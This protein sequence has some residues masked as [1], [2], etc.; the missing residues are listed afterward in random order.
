MEATQ[1]LEGGTKNIGAL[2]KVARVG[3]VIDSSGSMMGREQE[4]ISGF[5]EQLDEIL[6][7]PDNVSTYITVVDFN[8]E[9]HVVC[10]N[11]PA[12]TVERMKEGDYN[13][14]GWTALFDAIGKTVNIMEKHGEDGDSYLLVLLTDGYENHSVEFKRDTLKRLVT[15]RQDRGDWTIT[16]LVAGLDIERLLADVGV[17]GGNMGMFTASAAGVTNAFKGMSDGSRTYFDNVSLSQGPYST[18]SFYSISETDGE[19]S[20]ND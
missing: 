17:A 9:V 12:E 3:I 7:A 14:E 5:N 11:I 8:T 18:D 15:D 19:D 1:P 13:A 20:E 6:K 10:E 16:C 2:T 4:V